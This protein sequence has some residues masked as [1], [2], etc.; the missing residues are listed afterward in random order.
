MNIPTPYRL[1]IAAIVVFSAVMI[2][3]RQDLFRSK[4][5]DHA[6]S[7]T[8]I[9]GRVEGPAADTPCG[10]TMNELLEARQGMSWDEM[11]QAQ[12]S[13]PDMVRCLPEIAVLLARPGRDFIEVL[14]LAGTPDALDLSAFTR[15]LE[16]DKTLVRQNASLALAKM[17]FKAKPAL[18]SIIRAARGSEGEER[19]R[20]V[21]AATMVDP[22]S[23]KMW[24]LL[25][26][27]YMNAKDD[28][29]EYLERPLAMAARNKNW[30]LLSL[31]A[32]KNGARRQKDQR[33]DFFI[34]T[35]VVVAPTRTETWDFL[36]EFYDRPEPEESGFID[37]FKR[38]YEG[39]PNAH[40]ADVRPLLQQLVRR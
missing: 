18:D 4:G 20:H 14:G 38:K 23:Q 33:R 28:E 26:E 9:G 24:E 10:R 32:I 29:R 8:V 16:D 25:S 6:E 13:R 22:T 3:G 34:E 39:K 30:N 37:A 2:A 5:S 40:P 7:A 12:G 27:F 1:L 19:K 31:E 35:L 36:W 15:L 17:R 21:R 11:T